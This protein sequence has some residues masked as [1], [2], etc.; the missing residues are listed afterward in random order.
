MGR[1]MDLKTGG[2]SKTGFSTDF[3]DFFRKLLPTATRCKNFQILITGKFKIFI[4]CNFDFISK[5]KV[6]I[7]VGLNALFGIAIWIQMAMLIMVGLMHFLK[8]AESVSEM[9][10]CFDWVMIF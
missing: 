7:R 8:M 1:C 6:F 3:L 9:S 10:I 2:V 4:A 5:I